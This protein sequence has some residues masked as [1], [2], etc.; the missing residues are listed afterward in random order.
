[1]KLI[2]QEGGDLEIALREVLRG[3]LADFNRNEGYAAAQLST[4][5]FGLFKAFTDKILN[6]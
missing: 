1:M 6:R 5:I 4:Y 3:G 2:L